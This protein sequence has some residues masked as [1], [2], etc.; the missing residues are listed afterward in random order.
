MESV[1]VAIFK[2]QCLVIRAWT[3]GANCLCVAET[4][5]GNQIHAQE[6]LESTYVYS[7][8]K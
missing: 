5:M 8:Y 6:D 4:A 1:Y 7:M 3:T 2:G